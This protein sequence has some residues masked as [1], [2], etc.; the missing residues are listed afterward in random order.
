MPAEGGRPGPA[1]V[2][3]R[4]VSR[5]RGRLLTGDGGAGPQ[6]L[7][8]PQSPGRR[9]GCWAGTGRSSSS[10]QASH[11]RACSQGGSGAHALPTPLCPPF[12]WTLGTVTPTLGWPEMACDGSLLLWWWGAGEGLTLMAQSFALGSRLPACG[13][14]DWGPSE[15]TPNRE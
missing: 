8:A 2:M 15:P 1:R 10:C 12:P 14:W 7:Q 9:G 3:Q 13:S 5:R 11:G 6:E 4:A